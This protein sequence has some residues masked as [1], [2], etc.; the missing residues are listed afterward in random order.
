[1]TALAYTAGVRAPGPKL[2]DWLASAAL[3]VAAALALWQFAA[4]VGPASPALQRVEL[5]IRWAADAVV[6]DER[7][8]PVVAAAVAPPAPPAVPTPQPAEPTRSAET[9]P[10]VDAGQ[11]IDRAPVRRRVVAPA[12]EPA[13]RTVP[14]TPAEAPA[15]VPPETSNRAEAAPLVAVA[16]RATSGA[17]A[18]RR[19]VP[20]T[21]PAAIREPSVAAHPAPAVAASTTAAAPVR[22]VATDP[23]ARQRWHT[24]LERLM[25]EHKHYPMQARRMRQQG[26][27]TVEARFSAEGELLRCDVAG[28][29]G[30]RSL[31]Q[32]A[33]KLVRTA[34]EALRAHHG[35]G[36]L[37]ELRIPIAYELSGS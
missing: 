12:P 7:P 16:Q 2:A 25:R 18:Q 29:S 30:F 9:R 4:S 19:G 24:H 6:P 15:I 11:T 23:G 10:P 36:E 35:P 21:D 34:A 17:D 1:M 13:T 14:K 22:P 37:A 20:D 28:S 33:L 26:V 32:A 8:E 3:H 5:P 31:D 27:V